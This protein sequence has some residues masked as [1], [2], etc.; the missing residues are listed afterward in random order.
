MKRT[1]HKLTA[2]MLALIMS[3]G[4]VSA[5]SLAEDD[6]AAAGYESTVT[7][8]YSGTRSYIHSDS[9]SLW[10]PS[11]NM[12][13]V[14]AQIDATTN[15]NKIGIQVIKVLIYLNGSFTTFW[16]NYDIY[17]QNTDNFFYIT[18]LSSSYSNFYFKAV[19]KFYVEVSPGV[20]E[21]DTVTTGPVL[22]Q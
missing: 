2:L 8:F 3:F 7:N 9:L 13:R 18:T 16:Q 17:D 11:A 21:T 1:I 15:C 19:C 10:S 5:A 4:M 14:K 6:L 20:I 12:L 22:C